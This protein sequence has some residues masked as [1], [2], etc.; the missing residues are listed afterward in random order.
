MRQV[1]LSYYQSAP[2]EKTPEKQKNSK[3]NSVKGSLSRTN[4]NKMM[5]LF[6]RNY[7]KVQKVK[8]YDIPKKD[9]IL[10]PEPSKVSSKKI[11]NPIRRSP[12]NML[13]E[14]PNSNPN[15]YFNST[16]PVNL[17]PKVSNDRNK[18]PGVKLLLSSS[19]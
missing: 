14:N 7:P 3:Y 8:T 1:D 10:N 16:Q 2:Q 6:A 5:E 15:L 4:Q 12:Q 19:L 9:P 11:T 18:S 13:V 17:S